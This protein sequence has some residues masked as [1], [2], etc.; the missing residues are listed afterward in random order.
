MSNQG[1]PIFDARRAPQRR[2][3]VR[4]GLCALFCAV[5]LAAVASPAM[6]FTG[7]PII[8]AKPAV[9]VAGGFEMKGTV[10]PYG[11]DTTYHFEYGTTTAYGASLP[12]PDADVGI[13][14]ARRAGFPDRDRRPAE[15]DLP[16]PPRRQQLGR[17][18]DEHR[19]LVH[20]VR[21]RQLPPA[22][23]HRTGHRTQ[24][25]HRPEQGRGNP[26]QGAEAEGPHDPRHLHRDDALQPQR[27]E[28]GQIR[29]H[30]E[31][32]MPG[33]LAPPPRSQ[34]QDGQGPREAWAPSSD[35]KA[36]LR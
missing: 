31:R 23:G 8:E 15:H 24:D 34:G 33:H 28:E 5:A 21:R 20:D 14:P 10:N 1:S 13:G 26:P 7:P 36:A 11:L 29:L 17:A 25:P 19:R 9:A 27:R 12:V 32:R 18:D 6:A 2:R 16:L 22:A 30:Q 4:L 35:R 3:A